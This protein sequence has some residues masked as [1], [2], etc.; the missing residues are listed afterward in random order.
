MSV[1]KRSWTNRDGTEGVAWVAA[2]ADHSGKRRIR[3]FPRQREALAFHTAVAGELRGGV[4][5]PDAASV[6]VA[7][8][9]RL[10]L[11]CE[12]AGLERST[13]DAYRQHLDRH[14]VPL[15]GAIKLSRSP[16]PPCVPSRTRSRS[17]ARP[18]WC[19]RHASRSAPC[20]QMRRSAGWSGK[21]WCGLYAVAVDAVRMPTAT[22]ASSRSVLIFRGPRKSAPSSPRPRAAATAR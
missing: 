13:V 3:S 14:I 2:Y 6:T 15:I 4:H 21:T 20:S 5:V 7:E 9:G 1:R 11:G 22:T 10:W 17:I 16:S 19:A 12:A 8:A 18:P